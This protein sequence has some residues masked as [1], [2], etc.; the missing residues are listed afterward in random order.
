MAL[1]P[2]VAD[3]NH[4]N[5]VDFGA[6]AK[7]GAVGVI[8]KA[9]QGQFVDD[10]YKKRR[11]L[12]EAA[13]LAWGA[14]DFNTGDSV[15]S[16]VARF[17]QTAQPD[18]ETS[19]WLD[20]EDNKV[21]QMSLAQAQEFLDRVDQAIGRPCGIY[22]GN[23][24]KELLVNA[25]APSVEFFGQHPLWL[26]QYK[27]VRGEVSL[28]ELNKLIALPLAWKE[29]FLLQY[30]GDGIG[31]MPH[32][33]PGL[34]AGAD[35]S[36]FNGSAADL[37]ARWNLGPPAALPTA[38]ASPAQQTPAQTTGPVSSTAETVARLATE[39]AGTAKSELARL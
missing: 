2:L 21:S 23:R 38:A 6:L 28:E 27:I 29:Y 13:G 9:T 17:L 26:C 32:T 24:A 25:S 31:P 8:H 34:E 4:A 11:V 7:A 15:A 16:Q 36:V 18:F 3:M 10:E 33:M 1:T 14:Y 20:F 12:A 22:S 39:I 30:T 5:S 19:M 35:L 37:R